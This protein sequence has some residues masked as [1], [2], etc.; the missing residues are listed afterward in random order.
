MWYPV[1][2]EVANQMMNG[3]ER[4]IGM[5]TIYEVVD[6]LT[7]KLQHLRLKVNRT[8]IDSVV[9]IGE[10]SLSNPVRV[11]ALNE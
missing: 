2:L 4:T 11:H 7:V 10:L 8:S 5:A 3:I 9:I 6:W 1:A